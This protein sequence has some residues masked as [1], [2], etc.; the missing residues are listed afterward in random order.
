MAGWLNEIQTRVDAV[1]HNL[2]S[3]DAVFLLQIRVE[4]RGNILNDGIPAR[5]ER[6]IVN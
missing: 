3:V 4:T 2:L 5:M 6:R 1:I